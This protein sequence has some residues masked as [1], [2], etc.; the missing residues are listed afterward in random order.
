M[1][2]ESGAVGSGVGCGGGDAPVYIRG[3]RGVQIWKCVAAEGKQ[4]GNSWAEGQKRSRADGAVVR[5]PLN[6]QEA[7]EREDRVMPWS[8]D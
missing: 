8:M 1:K 5:M 4:P 7:Y 6:R 2:L 3:R